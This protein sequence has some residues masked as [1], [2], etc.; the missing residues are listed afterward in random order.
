MSARVIGTRRTLLLPDARARVS[1][2]GRKP[3]VGEQ[4]ARVSALVVLARARGHHTPGSLAQ[5]P[6]PC[7]ASSALICTRP[8]VLRTRLLVRDTPGLRHGLARG[9]LV[10]AR[11]RRASVELVHD[12]GVV[13]RPAVRGHLEG[14]RWLWLW[15]WL[16]PRSVGR[17]G[18]Q[19]GE[20]GE[21]EAHG[22]SVATGPGAST[23]TPPTR[24][25]AVRRPGAMTR[26]V[27]CHLEANHA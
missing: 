7:L 19:A 4:S 12:P 23:P 18:E 20:R 22:P 6:P 21:G 10:P 3:I 5:H 15:L 25:D 26:C 9:L 16:W 11:R 8:R 17:A 13:R 14:A 1:H 27:T 24:H 2:A